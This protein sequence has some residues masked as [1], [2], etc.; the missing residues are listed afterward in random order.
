MLLDGKRVS[1]K[2]PSAALSAGVAYVPEDRQVFPTLSVRQN[3]ELG[4]KRAGK[5]AEAILEIDKVLQQDPNHYLA[6]RYM[7]LCAEQIKKAE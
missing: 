6:A 3:L 1:F 7:K 5:F 2:T 4:L